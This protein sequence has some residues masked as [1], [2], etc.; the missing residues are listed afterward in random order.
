MTRKAPEES[1]DL[2]KDEN[3]QAYKT[4]IKDNRF[5]NMAIGTWVAFADGKLVSS[6]PT[7]DALFEDLNA[8]GINNCF[9]SEIGVPTR[10]VRLPLR[11]KILSR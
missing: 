7:R 4:A 6:K 10:V 3:Y 11:F 1:P 9:I 2:A 5:A 8:Q